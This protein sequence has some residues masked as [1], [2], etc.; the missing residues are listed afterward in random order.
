MTPDEIMETPAG[1]LDKMMDA[2]NTFLSF[3][4]FTNLKPGTVADWVNVNPDKW[5]IVTKVNGW[6]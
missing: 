2:E 5:K 4:E 6:Q 3:Q 1:L